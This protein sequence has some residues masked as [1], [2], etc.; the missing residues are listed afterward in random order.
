[1]RKCTG[2]TEESWCDN[3]FSRIENWESVKV[4]TQMAVE[5]EDSEFDPKPLMSFHPP[6]T[7]L[8]LSTAGNGLH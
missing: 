3:W 7:L 2:E 5:F 8:T 4:P 1:M 6:T